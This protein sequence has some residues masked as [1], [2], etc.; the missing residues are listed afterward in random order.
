MIRETLMW[1]KPQYDRMKNIYKKNKERVG[2]SGRV[3]IFIEFP[4]VEFKIYQD[5]NRC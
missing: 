2:M 1:S 5:S 4:G 3:Y